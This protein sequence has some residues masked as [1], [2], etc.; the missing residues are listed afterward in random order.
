MRPSRRQFV[1]LSTGLLA[2]CGV[3]GGGTT[4]SEERVVDAGPVGDYAADGVYDQF[5]DQGF[6]V[7]RRAE[8]V[9]ALSSICTHRACTL[10]AAPDRSF[11]CKCHGSTF[12]ADG[13]ATKGPAVRDLPMLFTTITTDGRF[14]VRVPAT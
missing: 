4:A 6:F 14:L 13:K 8:K 11:L 2:G 10:N 9:F 5:R 7:I 3:E 12:D 1:I